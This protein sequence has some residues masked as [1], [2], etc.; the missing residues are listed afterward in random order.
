MRHL[1]MI[2]A[3]ISLTACE[4]KPGQTFWVNL[5]NPTQAVYKNVDNYFFVGAGQSNM[6]HENLTGVFPNS[7]NVAVGGSTLYMWAKGTPFYNSMVT[8]C[9]NQTKPCVLL[10]WQGEAEGAD[11]NLDPWATEFTAMI[12][13]FRHD[14]GYIVPVVYVQIG[15]VQIG[16]V[17]PNWSAIQ[18][19]QASVQH[20]GSMAMV[21]AA[22]MFPDTGDGLHYGQD[23]YAVMQARMYTAWEGLN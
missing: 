13:S 6:S 9:K 4:K 11:F 19:Q 7:S 16:Q 17:T 2:L 5:T 22:D 12:T 10:F 1:P 21:S 15:Q 8:A 14:V 18:A 23:Q 20:L 3:L